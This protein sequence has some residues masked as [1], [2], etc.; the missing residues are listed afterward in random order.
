MREIP[1][2]R[3]AWLLLPPWRAIAA[4]ITAFSTS[5]SGRS[6]PGEVGDR[7]RG[8]GA[9][10]TCGGRS[11]ASSSGPRPTTTPRSIAFSSSRTFPGQSCALRR[12]RAGP[13]DPLELLALAPGEALEEVR[14]QQRDV[15]APLAQRRHVDLDDV[16][17]VDRGPR[18][19]ARP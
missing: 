5:A 10:R 7:P 12:S 8:R 15:L 2:A 6:P 4:A 13:G 3:A 19:T 16:E 1:R 9:G 14:G 11:A 17:A 18:G